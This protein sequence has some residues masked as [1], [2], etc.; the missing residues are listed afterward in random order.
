MLLLLLLGAAYDRVYMVCS[1]TR[2]WRTVQARFRSGVYI[3]T[4]EGVDGNRLCDGTQHVSEVFTVASCEWQLKLGVIESY[5]LYLSLGLA[6][7]WEYDG[8]ARTEKVMFDVCALDTRGN[9]HYSVKDRNN[10]FVIVPGE[11]PVWKPFL[12]VTEVTSLLSNSKFTVRCKIH[13]LNR[14]GEVWKVNRLPCQPLLPPKLG[15]DLKAMLDNWF[16]SD[17]S[18]VVS[19]RTIP[20]HRVVLA[21]RSSVFRAMFEHNMKESGEGRVDISDCSYEAVAAMLKF[22]YCDIPPDFD[23][24]SPNELLMVAD[25]YDV[26]GLKRVCER[27]ILGKL[28]INNAVHTLQQAD[29]LN[30]PFLKQSTLAFISVNLRKVMA[31]EE[32]QEITRS[33]PELMQVVLNSAGQYIETKC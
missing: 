23:D 17:V 2:K 30:A 7:P 16:L 14:G 19:D 9:K 15:S 1:N 4:L 8:D 5:K 25:K 20:A 13:V 27:D 3:W 10:V 18:L 29:R 22:M 28:D 11:S 32:W 12:P 33:H 31:T 24:V 6:M 21:S 26:P